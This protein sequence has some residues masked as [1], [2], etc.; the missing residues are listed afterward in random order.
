MTQSAQQARTLGLVFVGVTIV[1]AVVSLLIHKARKGKRLTRR[2]FDGID[3]LE[4]AR[5]LRDRRTVMVPDI[6][7]RRPQPVLSADHRDRHIHF[8]EADGF[9]DIPL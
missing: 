5:D 9:E 2:K 4:A 8:L 6:V 7:L 3:G 1:V